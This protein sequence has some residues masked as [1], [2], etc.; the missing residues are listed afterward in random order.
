MRHQLLAAVVAGAGLFSLGVL[1]DGFRAITTEGARRLDVARSPRSLPEARLVDHLGRSFGWED[2]AGSSVL[3]EFI[4]TRC[5]D[6]CQKMSS[7]LGALARVGPLAQ[8]DGVRFLSITFDPENDTVERMGEVASHYGADGARWRF[9][10]IADRA[11]LAATLEVFGVVVL[12]SPGRGFEHNAA[13][14]GVNPHRQLARIAD[15][16]EG[17]EMLRWAR[18]ES[19]GG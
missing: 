6:V 11:E 17:E 7:D 16:D 4:F 1:T 12:P 15:I 9:A 3:V 8:D 14:H 18:L 19:S 13:L 5:P 2:L 10:R